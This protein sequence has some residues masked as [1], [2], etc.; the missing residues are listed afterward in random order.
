[1]KLVYFIVSL[2]IVLSLMQCKSA[3][4][5]RK[6]IAPRDSTKVKAVQIIGS[7]DSILLINNTKKIL[8][9]GSL[10]F[11]TFSAKVRLDIETSTGMQPDV[12]ANIKMIKDS[13][14]WVSLSPA[15]INYEVMRIYIFKDSIILLDKRKHEVKY[16]SLSY[17]RDLTNIPFNLKTLQN[18]IIGNPIFINDSNFMVKKFETYLLIASLTSEFKSLITISSPDNLLQHCKLDDKD[19]YQNRTADFTYG[20][21]NNSNGFPFSTYR[22]IVV[23]EKN[24]LDVRMNFKQYDFNKD[25]SLSYNVPKSYKKK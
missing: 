3:R 22:Q 21:Y 17:L 23:T 6:A 13:V 24:K 7:T 8:R 14:I 5:I 16:R 11:T 2:F 18:L 1:M 4:V 9:K 10:D 25:L 19:M 20:Y 12:V 15:L